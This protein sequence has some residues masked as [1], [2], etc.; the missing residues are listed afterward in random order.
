LIRTAPEW[1]LNKRFPRPGHPKKPKSF[2]RN[3]EPKKGKKP[4][5]RGST[6]EGH[7]SLRPNKKQREKDIVRTTNPPWN[8]KKGV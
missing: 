4:E 1:P 8:T 2:F 5:R 6:E 7:P 3:L